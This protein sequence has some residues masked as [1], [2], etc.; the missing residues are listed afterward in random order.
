MGYDFVP[1]HAIGGDEDETIYLF[2]FL[3]GSLRTVA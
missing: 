2:I 1:D 3:P